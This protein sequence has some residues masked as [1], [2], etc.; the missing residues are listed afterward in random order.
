[1][2]FSR[3]HAADVDAKPGPHRAASAFDKGIGE[4]LGLKAFGL[5]QVEL[6]A[7]AQTSRHNH[8][9]DGA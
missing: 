2:A 7:G 9:H 4:A 1:M 3:I 6:P 5:Y 8:V